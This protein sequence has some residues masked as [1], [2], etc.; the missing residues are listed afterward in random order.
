MVKYLS[1]KIFSLKTLGIFQT[2]EFF[3]DFS[4]FIQNLG[5]S[6]IGLENSSIPEYPKFIQ[7]YHDL[8][9]KF[10][11]D[12]REKEYKNNSRYGN[13][14]FIEYSKWIGNE[15][16]NLLQIYID[17]QLQVK[18]LREYFVL[19]LG[20]CER[21]DY[22][23]CNEL[24]FLCFLFLLCKFKLLD[25][26]SYAHLVLI[27]YLDYWRFVRLIQKKFLLEPAGSLGVWGLDD[28]NFLPFL[29]GASQLSSHKFLKP[30]SIRNI[31]ILN[32]YKNEYMY[33]EAINNMIEYKVS[34]RNRSPVLNDITSVKSWQ[35]VYFGLLRM[36]KSN[37]L[38]KLPVMQHFLFGKFINYDSSIESNDGE[39]NDD[40]GLEHN[41]DCCGNR[42]PSIYFNNES[43]LF[44]PVD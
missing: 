32:E 20:N 24:Y 29:F 41:G 25:A 26:S 30:C 17:D 23:T 1:K 38:G 15:F 36:Y 34:L 16:S 9:L 3:S 7:K 2:S 10:T 13:P 31:D 18:E 39:L 4:T 43:K 5:D 8:I 28:F 44:H 19:S 42:I 11:F 6:V 37:V 40:N 21:L 14:Y 35:K 22:G 12:L 33:F 27:M